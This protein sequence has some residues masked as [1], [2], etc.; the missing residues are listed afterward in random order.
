[1]LLQ[2]I[3][4]KYFFLREMTSWH[5]Q[6]SWKCDVIM[7]ENRLRQSMRMLGL[8]RIILPNFT[9]IRF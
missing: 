1:V 3:P 4:L 5:W 8:W 9:S 2:L 6:P 7:S